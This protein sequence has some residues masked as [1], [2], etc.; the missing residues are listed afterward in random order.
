M[1][2]NDKNYSGF[3]M[4]KLENPHFNEL[5]AKVQDNL[6]IDIKFETD[7]HVTIGLFIENIRIGDVLRTIWSSIPFGCIIK[8][9][10]FSSQF[11]NPDASV[12]KFSIR[13]SI[14]SRLNSICQ[15][16][17]NRNMH[18]IYNPHIT[19]GY[20]PPNTEL[21]LKLPTSLFTI[22]GV[23]VSYNDN[24]DNTHTMHIDPDRSYSIVITNKDG[25][26]IC[27]EDTLDT[28]AFSN[29]K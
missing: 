27:K 3:V 20:L 25:K 4:L 24:H 14:L 13:D 15:S 18:P 2:N 10:E 17:P 21:K 5:Q 8:A 19:F 28:D 11:M 6:P 1:I 16:F 29:L 23:M 22:S 7:C 12:V 9:D 26:P